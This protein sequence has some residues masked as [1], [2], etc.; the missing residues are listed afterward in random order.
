MFFNLF[1]NPFSWPNFL[2]A[3]GVWNGIGMVAYIIDNWAFT[4]C[5]KPCTRKLQAFIATANIMY[6]YA[7]TKSILHSRHTSR[8]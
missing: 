4:E 6:L 2:H 5:I 3:V 7:F 1:L 8:T